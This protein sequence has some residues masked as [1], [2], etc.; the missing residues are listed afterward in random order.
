MMISNNEG[1]A[2]KKNCTIFSLVIIIVFILIT[3][4]VP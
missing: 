3:M 4:L 1:G 2:M